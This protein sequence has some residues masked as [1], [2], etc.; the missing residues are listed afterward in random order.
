MTKRAVLLGVAGV[1]GAVVVSD[2]IGSRPAVRYGDGPLAPC[3]TEPNCSLVRVRLAADA[4]AVQPVVLAAVQ[5]HAT[6]RTGRAV[7]V[8]PTDD[9]VRALFA[10]GP[11]RDRL[12]AA[13]QADESG[14]SVLWVRS[15]AETGRS[16]LG[17]NRARVR[18][19]VDTVEAAL[20]ER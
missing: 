7:R 6:W 17:V 2:R 8:T 10:V 14:G 19:V 18:Q 1:V 20:A 11:F 12:A 15:Q 4:G 16:D 5:S 9:G 13:V 3:G